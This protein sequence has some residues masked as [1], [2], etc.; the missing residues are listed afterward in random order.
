MEKIV[1]V[2]ASFAEAERADDAYF[3]SLTPAQRI[4]HLL[5]ICG[6]AWGDADGPAARLE[7]VCRVIDRTRG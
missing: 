4:D 3:A 5:Q 6:T 2:F 1:R 7:R